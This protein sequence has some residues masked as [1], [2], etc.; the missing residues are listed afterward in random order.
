MAAL[1]L[2]YFAVEMNL[3]STQSLFLSVAISILSDRC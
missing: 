3:Q 2:S 1:V